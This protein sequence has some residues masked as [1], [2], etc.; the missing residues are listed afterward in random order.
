MVCVGMPRGT[1]SPYIMTNRFASVVLGLATLA[2]SVGAEAPNESP[3]LTLS[4]STEPS[5]QP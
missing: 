1:A 5:P 2:G 4:L 3:V